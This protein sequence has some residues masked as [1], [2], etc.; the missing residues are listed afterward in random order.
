MYRPWRSHCLFLPMVSSL[1]CLYVGSVIVACI[2]IKKDDLEVIYLRLG[3]VNV[4]I[5]VC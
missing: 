1:Y 2:C 4:F 5:L 3:L